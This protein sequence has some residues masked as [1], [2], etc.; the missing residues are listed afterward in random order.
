[1]TTTEQQAIN[2]LH[3]IVTWWEIWEKSENPS[4]LENPPIKEA[5][6]V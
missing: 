2:L 1:M 6:E 4:D 3:E 5:K